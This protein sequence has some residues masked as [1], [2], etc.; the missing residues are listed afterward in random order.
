M[1]GPVTIGL[2]DTSHNIGEAS[3][4]AF[5]NVSSHHPDRSG[6]AAQP[7]GRH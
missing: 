4:A 7:L 2:F 1:T 3:T 5:D 6:P